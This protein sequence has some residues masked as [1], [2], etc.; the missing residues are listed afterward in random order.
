MGKERTELYIEGV[1]I[2]GCLWGR[3]TRFRRDLRDDGR[4]RVARLGARLVRC[5]LLLRS[6]PGLPRRRVFL[7]FGH[8]CPHAPTQR[9]HA[10]DRLA[11]AARLVPLAEC[12]GATSKPS[13]VALRPAP[14]IQAGSLRK[15]HRTFSAATSAQ[16]SRTT[17]ELPAG[18]EFLSPTGYDSHR[19]CAIPLILIYGGFSPHGL[20]GRCS[21]SP[22]HPPRRRA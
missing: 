6:R 9:S 20:P 13:P 19:E 2:Q 16:G 15:A 14:T 21:T 1:A 8:R 17:P 5:P 11:R 22:S 10:R 12:S 4:G 3:E 18:P 7:R